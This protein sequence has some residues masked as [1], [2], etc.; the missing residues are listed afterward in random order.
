MTNFA[1]EKAGGRRSTVKPF[2]V[3]HSVEETKVNPAAL[4]QVVF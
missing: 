3:Q 4:Q 1:R 2:Q